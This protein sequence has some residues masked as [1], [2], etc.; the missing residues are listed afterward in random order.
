VKSTK[1]PWTRAEKSLF[2]TPLLL[3]LGAGGVWWW[4][5]IS[6]KRIFVPDSKF[7]FRL[8]FSPDNRRFIVDYSGKD[9]FKQSAIFDVTTRSK[10]C[11]LKPP[12]PARET[13]E[14]N[15]SPD[16]TQIV[17]GYSDGST[18]TVKVEING[19]MEPN[20]IGKI[21]MWNAQT[22]RITARWSYAPPNEDSHAEVYFSRDGRK[23]IGDGHPPAIFDAFSGAR[24]RRFNASVAPTGMGRFNASETLLAVAGEFYERIEVR[25]V[26]SNRLL[27]QHK[28]FP[29]SGFRWASNNVLGVVDLQNGKETRLLLWDG[30]TRRPLPSP[31][32]TEIDQMSMNDAAPLVAM[33]QVKGRKSPAHR[34]K[35]HNLLVWNY[36][37]NRLEWSRKM[38]GALSDLD[39]SPDGKWLLVREENAQGH[40]IWIFDARGKVHFHQQ[41][42]FKLI[43][44]LWVPDSK[45]LAITHRAEVEILRAIP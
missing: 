8:H 26:K 18:G 7:I 30:N 32:V 6:T 42:D 20:S 13:H 23:L 16:G 35:I 12:L 44:V 43:D 39:W 41:T 33:T 15:W 3:A 37:S 29:V 10:I 2:L 1:R 19:K 9:D 40:M 31:S 45:Q 11:D 27:W 36:S 38:A 14:P 17:A 24:L 21:V 28:V 34:G 25:E 4:Q 22:G 5:H